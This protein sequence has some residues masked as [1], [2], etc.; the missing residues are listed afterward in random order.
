[1]SQVAWSVYLCVGHTGV[2]CKAA[3]QIEMPFGA[4]L[5]DPWN[6]IFDGNLDRT[7]PFAAARGDKSTMRPCSILLWTVVLSCFLLT[8]NFVVVLL[9]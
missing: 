9:C 7:N 8:W 4:E 6:H 3:E 5:C 2:L 1:M